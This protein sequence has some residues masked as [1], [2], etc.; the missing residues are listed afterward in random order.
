MDHQ[1]VVGFIIVVQSWLILRENKIRLEANH[2]MEEASELINLAAHD[3][4]WSCVFL[5][6]ALMQGNL[7]L[8]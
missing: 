5:K 8:E 7:A 2:V 3:V 4:I 6:V 1:L